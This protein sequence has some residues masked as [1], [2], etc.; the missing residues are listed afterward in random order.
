MRILHV[1]PS[2]A[3]RGGGPAK[4]VPELCRELVRT[5]HQV[6]IYTTDFAVGGELDVPV[7]QAIR[8]DCG[9]ERWYFSTQGTGA[10]GWSRSLTRA[11]RSNLRDFDVVHIH[12][13]YRFTSTVSAYYARRYLVPYILWPH[14]A[15]DPFLYYR[16]RWRKN[17]YEALFEKRNLARAAAV[18]FATDEEMSLAQSLGLKF[19]GVVVP[20]GVD[21][22]LPADR[23]R[24]REQFAHD[25][26]ETHGK[27][28][29]LFLSRVNFKKGLDLLA[30]A[31]GAV[32]RNRPDVHLFIAGP[33]NE[34]YAAKVR[35]WL[36]EERVLDRVTFAGMLEGERKEAAFAAADIFVLPSYTENFGVAIAEA[37]AVGVPVII[38]NKVNIWREIKD[39]DAGIVV[40]CDAGEL[41]TAITK[42]LDDDQLRRNCGAAGKLLVAEKF[43]WPSIVVRMTAVY[44]DVIARSLDQKSSKTTP[45]SAKYH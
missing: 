8:D 16:H 41:A 11:L 31:F 25:W 14:G 39:A 30:K 12:A 42:L 20:Y 35:Q 40:N 44:R 29:I 18:H 45:A 23:D 22:A 7:D 3:M 19:R 27:K 21:V 13:L 34:G 1:I 33:D 10:F 28:I 26:P 4:A 5:G 32:A 6:T 24:V 15:L 2:L 9:I 17:V 37:L 38:S 36:D 43:D